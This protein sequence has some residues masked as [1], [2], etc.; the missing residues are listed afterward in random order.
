M[1]AEFHHASIFFS[2]HYVLDLSQPWDHFLAETLHERMAA[3]VGESWVNVTLGGA[4]LELPKDG[5]AWQVPGSHVHMHIQWP[6]QAQ[7]EAQFLRGGRFRPRECSSL[8]T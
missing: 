5:G 2:G 8:T 1:P 4:G 7:L 3:E 6:L